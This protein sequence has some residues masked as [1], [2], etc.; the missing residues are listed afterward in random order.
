MVVAC[1]PKASEP[2]RA[3]NGEDRL[4]AFLE[5]MPAAESPC[6]APFDHFY[7]ARDGYGS[8]KEMLH[9]VSADAAPVSPN[10]ATA[11]GARCYAPGPHFDFNGSHW[12]C[13]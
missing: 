5:P 1:E 9:V 12:C 11:R 3:A 8:S 13:R 6:E 7:R 2:R 4:A 10:E